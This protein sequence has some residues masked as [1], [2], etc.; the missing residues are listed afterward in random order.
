MRTVFPEVPYRPSGR[1]TPVLRRSAKRPLLTTATA[2][3]LVASG[4]ILGACAAGATS[5]TTTNTSAPHGAVVPY[6]VPIKPAI[7]PVGQSTDGTVTVSGA[8]RT[9]SLYVPASLP[10]NSPVPLL[11]ALHGGLGSGQGFEQ[12]TGFDGLAEAN[13]FIVVYP[14]G[15]PIRSGSNER[16]WNAGSCCSVAEQSNENVNDVGFISALITQL[17]GRY[18][19]DKNRVFAAGHSNGA[20]LAER[21][22]CQLAGQI[23]A[24]GVQSGTLPV[25]QCHPAK[26][27]A[28]L[29]IHGT[30]DQNVPIN[31]GGGSNSLNQDSYPPP[32]DGLKMLAAQ[33]GCPPSSTTS[34]DPANSAVNFEIWHPCKS[35]SVVEWAKVTGANHGWMGHPGSAAADRLSGGPPYQGFDSSAAIWSFLAAHPRPCRSA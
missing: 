7:N 12:Q 19:I 16:V 34:T 4:V 13:R 30:A 26:P 18:D 33:D 10:P 27:V 11:V 32:V 24:I 9:Y 22:A 3:L 5:A 14:D 25:D 23:V 31:G 15:T 35:G 8:E 17:E 2:C 21:L 6:G 20:M 28:A 1:R 29:E